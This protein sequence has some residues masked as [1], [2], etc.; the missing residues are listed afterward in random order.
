MTG[1]GPPA[2][3]ERDVAARQAKK[4][5]RIVANRMRAEAHG[6]VATKG[7][8]RGGDWSRMHID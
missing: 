2:H 5:L 7:G 6:I 8:R 1:P 3:D 4:K